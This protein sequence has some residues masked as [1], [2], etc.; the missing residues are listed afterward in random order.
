MM[1]NE[2]IYAKAQGSVEDTIGHFVSLASKAEMTMDQ[3]ISLIETNNEEIFIT[4]KALRNAVKRFDESIEHAVD[5]DLIGS[6]KESSDNFSRSMLKIESQLD[7][8]EKSGLYDNASVIAENLKDITTA[9]NNPETLR[10]I[11]DNMGSLA[12][13]FRVLGDEIKSV[14]PTMERSFSDV[15]LAAQAAREMAEDGKEIITGVQKVVNRVSSGQ[16]DLGKLFFREDLYLGTRALL[17]KMETTMNDVN[18]YGLLFHLDKGWQRQRTRRINVLHQLDSASHF[19]GFLEEEIDGISTSLS[20]MFLLLQKAEE[21]MK[22]GEVKDQHFL[23]TFAELF[24]RV[25]NLHDVL[26]FYNQEYIEVK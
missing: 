9:V 10:D 12:S 15:S 13:Q 1:N 8:L 2:I 18:H 7:K 14:W 6:I 16:G 24:R 11:V 5:I 25:D 22:K 21:K 3:V 26:K 19:R 20:R 17:D 23:E 4:I